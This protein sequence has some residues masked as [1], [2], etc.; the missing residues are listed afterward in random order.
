MASLGGATAVSLMSDEAKADAGNVKRL[1]P[2]PRKR[3][4]DF[5]TYRFAGASN[6][7]LQSATKA[8]R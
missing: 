7:C 4:V 3:L 8:L 2:M 1:P 5:F 6:H